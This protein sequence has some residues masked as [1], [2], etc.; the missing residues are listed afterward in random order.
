MHVGGSVI[1]VCCMYVGGECYIS[2]L[3]VCRWGVL[4]QYDVCMKVGSVISVCCMYVGGECYISM[5]YVCPD[6]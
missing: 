5:M 6:V 2:M 4:Y 3:Y 1:S